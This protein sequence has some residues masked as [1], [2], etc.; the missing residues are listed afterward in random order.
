MLRVSVIFTVTLF[1][2]RNYTKRLLKDQTLL[3]LH[4]C[5]PK[6]KVH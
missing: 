3:R 4:N 6:T 5:V 1:L 2:S